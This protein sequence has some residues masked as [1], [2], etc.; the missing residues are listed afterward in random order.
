MCLWVLRGFSTRGGGLIMTAFLF[1]EAL[2]QTS[3]WTPT[4]NA[5]DKEGL[6]LF[7]LPVQ[8]S[9]TH[10]VPVLQQCLVALTR[11]IKPTD[12][13][14]SVLLIQ[15]DPDVWIS[16]HTGDYAFLTGLCYHAVRALYEPHLR[17]CG[18]KHVSFDYL[19]CGSNNCCM[20]FHT[21]HTQTVSTQE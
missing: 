7:H 17:I 10:I 19:N 11:N 15:G 5:V 14:I 20:Q 21:T 13:Q 8:L 6:R 18:Q 3:S 9:A 16:D 12:G 1:W 2:N 4:N